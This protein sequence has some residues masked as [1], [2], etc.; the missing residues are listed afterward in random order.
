MKT[1]K[2]IFLDIDGCVCP[3]TENYYTKDIYGK[4]T[5]NWQEE[6]VNVLKR[7]CDKFNYKIVISS[8]W[9]NEHDTIFEYLEKWNLKK[10]LHVQWKI[11]SI[12]IDRNDQIHRWI[13]EH[14]PELENF[15]IIDDMATFH[16]MEEKH[17]VKPF[18]LVGLQYKH[19]FLMQKIEEDKELCGNNYE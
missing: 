2:I 1:T 14:Q 13:E 12:G 11:D 10:Y 9:R 8:D 3:L 19:Y 16:D 17:H 4:I 7:F 18:C 6:A 5:Y 15:I